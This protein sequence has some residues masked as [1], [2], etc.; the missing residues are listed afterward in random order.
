MLRTTTDV[1]ML[2]PVLSTARKATRLAIVS[3]SKLTM[4]QRMSGLQKSFCYNLRTQLLIF[5]PNQERF[6]HQVKISTM[7]NRRA[8]IIVKAIRVGPM[9]EKK[10]FCPSRSSPSFS[11][12]IDSSGNRIDK[13]SA[14]R[15]PI[16]R[17]SRNS[18]RVIMRSL[19]RRKRTE[20]G[21][22]IYQTVMNDRNCTVMSKFHNENNAFCRTNK[23]RSWNS[24]QAQIAI[25][26]F[27]AVYSSSS[28]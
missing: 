21:Y 19:K 16:S 4:M 5:S 20:S 18:P 22:L 7:K 28:N 12:V 23:H 25:D 9:L 6:L 3:L 15:F 10:S 24:V 13:A 11:S 8:K 27:R 26:T 17:S 1:P 14:M 2:V